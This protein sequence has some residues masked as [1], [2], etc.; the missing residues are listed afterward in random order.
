[1]KIDAEV[2]VLPTPLSKIL[3]PTFEF[4]GIAY[5]CNS[6]DS[7]NRVFCGASYDFLVDSVVFSDVSKIDGVPTSCIILLMDSFGSIIERK[8]S[9]EDGKFSFTLRYDKY[10]ILIHELNKPRSFKSEIFEVDL[11]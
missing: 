10:F 5:P 7:V 11:R 2:F 8:V 1:M 6:L 9:G 4:S 3:I